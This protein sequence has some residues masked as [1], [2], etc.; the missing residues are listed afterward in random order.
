M[1][2]LFFVG[3][4]TVA[5]PAAPAVDLDAAV[6]PVAEK[7]IMQRVACLSGMQPDDAIRFIALCREVDNQLIAAIQ[8]GTVRTQPEAVTFVRDHTNPG[9]PATKFVDVM[10]RLGIKGG[11]TKPWVDVVTA[12]KTELATVV[13]TRIK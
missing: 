10:C 7:E 4:R 1:G 12:A 13:E 11:P 6:I 8:D 5:A 3:E 2:S 9:F